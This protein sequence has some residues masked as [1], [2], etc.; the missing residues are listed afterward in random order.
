MQTVKKV[1]DHLPDY[2]SVHK[3][4][5]CGGLDTIIPLFFLGEQYVSDF[6]PKDRVN[7]G[8]K[9]PIDL[10]LCDRC[11]LVQN[12]YTARQDFL[13][14]RHYWYRSGVTQTMKNQLQDVVDSA[15]RRVNSWEKDKS[16]D[17]VLDIGSNDGT[18]LRCYPPGFTRVGVEPATNLAAEGR[19]GLDGFIN[20]FWSYDAYAKSFHQK[21]KIVTACGMFYDLE[22][23]NAFIRDVA[24]VL[25]PEGLFVAQLMCL[26]Q[27]LENHDV[28]NLAHEHLEFYSL[29]SL[30][31]L[32]RTHGLEIFDVEEN[33]TNGGSYRLFV[34]HIG[35]SPG[36]SGEAQHRKTQAFLREGHMGLDRRGTYTNWF[37]LVYDSRKTC[38]DFVRHE[39]ALDK[40]V[41]VYGA[42]T[43]GNVIL[44]WYNLY[45]IPDKPPGNYASGGPYLI[46][47]AADRSPEKWG[48]YTVGTGIPIVSEKE[49]RHRN[50]D[51]Y[52]VLPYA[53]LKEFIY[54]EKEWL[55]KGGK[56]IVPLPT[57]RLVGLID[58]EIKEVGL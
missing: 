36:M 3:C 57:P 38:V 40:T 54:R 41:H 12:K 53:F 58:G 46:E 7:K 18:L 55:Q 24:R 30:A 34:R 25:H 56:F 33:D 10:E 44:Q 21:A 47:M 17:I 4:R 39:V 29:K 11:G 50:P 22:D 16:K 23:P 35:N 8:V 20:D 14:T 27:T 28:G 15:I 42:S 49:S 9:C 37:R 2:A 5:V 6:V 31:Y 19:E 48:K 52:L 32:F 51:Y 13:Y 1:P 26:K 45:G 43:K